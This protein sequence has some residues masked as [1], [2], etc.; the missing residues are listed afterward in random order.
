MSLPVSRT[1]A[2]DVMSEL[3]RVFTAGPVAGVFV[4][5][6]FFITGCGGDG[7]S[8]H[9]ISGTITYDGKPLE[10]GSIAL[11]PDV[12]AGKVA[13]STYTSVAD[14]AFSIPVDEGP[15]AGKYNLRIVSFD[16]SKMKLDVPEGTPINMPALFPPYTTQVEIPPPD[17]VL[18]VDVPVAKPAASGTK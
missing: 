2:E 15:I 10:L 6:L 7:L 18:K 14:G 13:P 17:G 4:A 1:L 16:K 11:E 8:R 9:A 3:R 5:S 12:S